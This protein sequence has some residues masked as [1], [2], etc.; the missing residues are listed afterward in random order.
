MASTDE[1][2]DAQLARARDDERFWSQIAEMQIET[3]EGYRRLA[4]KAGEDAAKADAAATD[5]KSHRDRAKARL[6]DIEAGKLGPDTNA[7]PLTRE[8]IRKITG[9][10]RAEMQQC[11]RVGMIA[12][13]LGDEAWSRENR[14]LFERLLT[15]QRRAERAHSKRRL[16]ELLAERGMIWARDKLCRRLTGDREC[17]ILDDIGWR[18]VDIHAVFDGRLSGFGQIICHGR[19]ARTDDPGDSAGARPRL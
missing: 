14:E 3:A 15:S 2:K 19:L 1:R 6:A 13:I 12:D 17:P 18:S 7:K 4:A 10:T 5:A 11:V 9:M 16:L 8:D